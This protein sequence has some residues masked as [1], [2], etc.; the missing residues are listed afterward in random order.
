MPSL[1]SIV[2]VSITKTTITLQTRNFNKAVFVYEHTAFAGDIKEYTSIE[3]VLVDF[4]IDTPAYKFA[5]GAF[6]Q[7][8]Q[9][10]SILIG[11]KLASESWVDN[12]TKLN[13]NEKQWFFYLPYSLAEADI[14]D[15]STMIGLLDKAMIVPHAGTSDIAIAEAIKDGLYPRVIAVAYGVNDKA[16]FLGGLWARCG[17]ATVGSSI[18][19]YKQ[20]K[21]LLPTTYSEADELALKEAQSNIF[22]SIAGVNVTYGDFKTGIG[23]Y[24]DVDIGVVWLKARLQES[25]FLVFLSN[26]KVAYRNDGVA[27]IE[28]AV[29]IVLDEAVKNGL[30]TDDPA[31][32]TKVPDVNTLT[33]QQR[34]SRILPSVE[35]NGQLAGAIQYVDGIVGKISA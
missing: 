8:V 30:L 29:K 34:D 13:R 12:L 7:D 2:K 16:K 32:K 9:P 6:A 1:N 14:A 17:L 27:A 15:V 18:W 5:S 22:T 33:P 23:E 19:A 26:E 4:A 35:F 28:T 20:I 11:K 21:G 25:V 3:A 24:F 10:S 31:P